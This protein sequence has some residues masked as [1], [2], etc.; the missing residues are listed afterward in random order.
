MTAQVAKTVQ[1][2][3]AVDRILSDEIKTRPLNPERVEELMLSFQSKGQQQP[4]KV[5]PHGDYY[6]SVVF[7][8]HRLA[9]AK[10]LAAKGLPIRR[11]PLG[12]VR[13]E[14]EDLDEHQALELK[15]TENAHRNEFVDPWEEGH[16]FAKLLQE[17]Y[18]GNLNALSD[19]IGKRT[20]YISDRT[21]V[22]YDLDP[23]LRQYVGKQLTMANTISLAKIGPA[24]KQVELAMVIV[25]TRTSGPMGFGGGAGRME[26]G[27]FAS[28]VTIIHECTCGCGNVHRD[29]RYAMATVPGEEGI[30]IKAI[31]GAVRGRP[32]FHIENPLA[33]G[34]SLC[35]LQLN[36]KERWAVE[37]P[38]GLDTRVFRI[39]RASLCDNC[40]RAWRRSR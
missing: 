37:L 27:R 7:G 29:L 20:S 36:L 31:V 21:R 5:R 28:K 38:R 10:Q 39:D 9:A 33:G 16:I 3:I 15:V 34:T 8:E 12:T 1:D 40:A 19:S 17:K 35:G 23:S 4:I 26:D 32:D 2:V 25:K 18:D 6:F 14:V 30:G 11:L 13:A 24:E 22:Y